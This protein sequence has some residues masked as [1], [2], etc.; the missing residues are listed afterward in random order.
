MRVH[1]LYEWWYDFSGPSLRKYRCWDPYWFV[2]FHCFLWMWRRGHPWKHYG[3]IFN[4]PY[5][6]RFACECGYPYRKQ[7][8]WWASRPVNESQFD[9]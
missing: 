9:V 8:K 7:D 1:R 4:S 2:R 6:T 5:I 3:S